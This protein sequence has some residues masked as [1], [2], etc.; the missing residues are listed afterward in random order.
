MSDE[1]KTVGL[2]NN[3]RLEFLVCPRAIILSWFVSLNMSLQRIWVTAG[4]VTLVAFVWLF[5][6][7][8]FHMIPQITCL[9]RC[10]VTLV[11]FVWLFSTVHF[12]V[13]PQMVCICCCSNVASN[14]LPEKRHNRIGYICLTFLHCAFSSV[15]SNG[16]HMLLLK[17]C[18]KW[19]TWEEA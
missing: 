6:S 3:V 10:K 9:D 1:D 19:P 12:Q 14:G 8:C 2:L 15:S 17:C 18:L 4:K 5:S 13:S 7:V 16:L 11:A